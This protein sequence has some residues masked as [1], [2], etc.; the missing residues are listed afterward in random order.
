MEHI[1][2]IP[3]VLE[4]QLE[5]GYT[6]TCALVPDLVTEADTLDQVQP[7]VADALGALIEIYE[8]LGRPMPVLLKPLISVPGRPIWAETLVQAASGGQPFAHRGST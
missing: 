6:I 7:H 3:L 1:Y 4:P 8:D 5:G 2:K